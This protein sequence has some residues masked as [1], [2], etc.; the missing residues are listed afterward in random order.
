MKKITLGLPNILFFLVF[1]TH[2][3]TICLNHSSSISNK[4]II[5]ESGFFLINGLCESNK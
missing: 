2:I 4:C 3:N 5:C 1:L